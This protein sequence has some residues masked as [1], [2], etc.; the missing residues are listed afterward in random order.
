MRHA[1]ITICARAEQGT[2]EQYF[3]RK[4]LGKEMPLYSFAAAKMFEATSPDI[5]I[6]YCLNTDSDEL[7]SLVSSFFPSVFIVKREGRLTDVSVPKEDVYRDSLLKAEKHFGKEYEFLI[8]L[9][10]TSP[11]RKSSDIPEAV[12]LFLE[13]KDADVVMSCVRSRRNPFYN[14]AMIDPDGFAKRVIQNEFT[15][16]QQAPLCYDIN[17]SIYVVSRDFLIREMTFDLWQGK[18]LLY[19]MQDLGVLR[20][21]SAVPS[22]LA[23]L[24]ASFYSDK[25]EKYR[26]VFERAGSI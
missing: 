16:S 1:L 24:I 18:I 6:D 13:N 7:I 26:E 10:I 4:I 5:Q 14:M 17:G 23:D 2:T 12:H 15:F 25:N 3:M 20:V 19:E 22:G 8:D 9:D 21:D 11:F